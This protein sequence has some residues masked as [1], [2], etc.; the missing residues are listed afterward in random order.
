MESVAI[1]KRIRVTVEFDIFDG[2]DM[3]TAAHDLLRY[4][5]GGVDGCGQEVVRVE[6]VSDDREGTD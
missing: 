6:N 4:G 5:M 1:T 2:V 3:D